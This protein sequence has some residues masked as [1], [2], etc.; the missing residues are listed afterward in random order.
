MFHRRYHASPSPRPAHPDELAASGPAFVHEVQVPMA[1]P[2]VAAHREKL[3]Q[4]HGG[5]GI[6]QQLKE[7]EEELDGILEEEKV[8]ARRREELEALNQRQTGFHDRRQELE[9]RI[10]QALLDFE[11]ES[12]A[13]VRK[14]RLRDEALGICRRYLQDLEQLAPEAIPPLRSE[15]A[16][17]RQLE[18]LADFE[19]RLDG[20][21][22]A[23]ERIDPGDAV[24]ERKV[25]L[26]FGDSFRRGLLFFLPYIGLGAVGLLVFL[27]LSGGGH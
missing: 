19:K 18:F 22:K 12:H 17:R 14:A 21:L 9:D 13:C 8:L 4:R 6:H 2:A 20:E 5:N 24:A 15:S 26:G 3:R 10:N 1:G 7:T 23:L 25:D 11:R 16:L 27:S